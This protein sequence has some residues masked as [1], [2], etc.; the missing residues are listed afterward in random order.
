MTINSK[1]QRKKYW[2][3]I[4]I[5]ECPVCGRN[6]SYRERMYSIK[7]IEKKDRYVFLT[8]YQTYDH[9]LEYEY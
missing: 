3:R 8:D 1:T 7:P 2:Y 4:Y 6:K 9:C 5:G